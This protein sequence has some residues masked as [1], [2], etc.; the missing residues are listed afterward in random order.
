LSEFKGIPT[1]LMIVAEELGL[2]AAIALA[3]EAGGERVVVPDTA[4]GSA[5]AQ[6]FGDEVARV[7]V[8]NWGGLHLYIPNW[9]DREQVLREALVRDNPEAS[10]NELVRLTGLSDRQIYR[11]RKKIGDGI[12]HHQ[13]GLLPLFRD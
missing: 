11:I 9:K 10:I 1:T 13:Q 12:E 4:K 2:A 8:S 7:L 5:I 3:D 6:R